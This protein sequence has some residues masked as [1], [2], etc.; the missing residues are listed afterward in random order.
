[1][2]KKKRIGE[3]IWKKYFKVVHVT[4]LTDLP[5][6]DCY[7]EIAHKDDVPKKMMDQTKGTYLRKSPVKMGI[8]IS[9]I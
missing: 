3:S 4:I 8:L 9:L 1:M 2:I 5:C 6:L 7:E